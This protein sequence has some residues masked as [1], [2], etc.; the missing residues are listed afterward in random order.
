MLMFCD[1]FSTVLSVVARYIGCLS[2]EK[3]QGSTP[4]NFMHIRRHVDEYRWN[5]YLFQIETMS[6]SQN[7]VIAGYYAACENFRHN[8][9]DM[10]PGQKIAEKIA[11]FFP[12]AVF[13]VVST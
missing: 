7:Q 8:T 9:V 3:F 13:I 11:E 10:C 6:Q 4:G 2:Y 1:K 12:A 5:C